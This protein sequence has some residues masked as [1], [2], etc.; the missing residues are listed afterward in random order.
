MNIRGISDLLKDGSG[1]LV[2]NLDELIDKI[3]EVKHNNIKCKNVNI[4]EYLL[5]N[6]QIEINDI[7]NKLIS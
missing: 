7:I 2:N 6:V 4:D 1:I 3:I 5:E